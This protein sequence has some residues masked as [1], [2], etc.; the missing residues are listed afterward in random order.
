MG[1]PVPRFDRRCAILRPTLTRDADGGPVS[2]FATL[3]TVW[4][5][6][7]DEGGREFRTSGALRAEARA[8]FYTRFYADISTADRISCEGITYDIVAVSETGRRQGLMIQAAEREGQ[9]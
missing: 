6:R 3:R 1:F 8:L 9:A 5:R 2:T 7:V 4:C